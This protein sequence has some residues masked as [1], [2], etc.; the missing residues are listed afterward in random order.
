MADAMLMG[1]SSGGKA[2]G[3]A[4]PQDV[5][6]GKTFSGDIGKEV[7]GALFVSQGAVTPDLATSKWF[8]RTSAT[9]NLWFSVCYG[10]GLFV[11]VSYTGTGDGVMTMNIVRELL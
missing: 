3:T 5:I 2:K 11:A 7:S 9:N 1:Q 4:L 6:K 10:N 8:S